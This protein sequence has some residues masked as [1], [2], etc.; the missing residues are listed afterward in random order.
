MSVSSA[1]V[2]DNSDP[3]DE[4]IRDTGKLLEDVYYEGLDAGLD[5]YNAIVKFGS[6][7]GDVAEDVVDELAKPVGDLMYGNTVEDVVDFVSTE[8]VDRGLNG[9]RDIGLDKEADWV[10][11]TGGDVIRFAG[12]AAKK[13]GKAAEDVIDW[14]GDAASDVGDFAEDVVDGVADPLYDV[15]YGDAIDD[16]K[17]FGSDALDEIGQAGED[18]LDAIGDAASDATD[19]A[20]DVIDDIGDAAGDGLD[21]VGDAA[22]DV[23]DWLGDLW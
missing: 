13:T 14:M 2:T 9:M 7:V 21:T 8:I 11:N 4:A 6:D 5:V 3:V 10:Q 15:V 22:E 19:A 18:A 16:V 20:G 12:E 1:L 17:K 23:G